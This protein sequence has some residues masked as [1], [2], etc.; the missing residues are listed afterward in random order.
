MKEFLQEPERG[1]IG[2]LE[3]MHGEEIA[4]GPPVKHCVVVFSED[5]E[6]VDLVQRH[7]FFE[8]SVIEHLMMENIVDGKMG[9]CWDA[10]A[11]FGQVYCLGVSPDDRAIQDWFAV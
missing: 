4:D 1:M 6:V 8:E 2:V 10:D 5:V 7:F 11:A 9:F 3:I